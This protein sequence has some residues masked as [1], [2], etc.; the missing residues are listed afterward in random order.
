MIL[1]QCPWYLNCF[2]PFP[3]SNLK[4]FNPPSSARPERPQLEHAQP[5]RPQLEHAQPGNAKPDSPR[6][7][8]SRRGSA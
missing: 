3:P 2:L 5:E 7:G 8:S 1:E 6:H 4:L